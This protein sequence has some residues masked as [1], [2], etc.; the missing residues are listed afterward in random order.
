MSNTLQLSLNFLPIIMTDIVNFRSDINPLVF[1]VTLEMTSYF[2]P[3]GY[4][5]Y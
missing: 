2:F 4:F 3:I 5:T 1:S